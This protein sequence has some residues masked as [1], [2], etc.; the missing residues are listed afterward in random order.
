[1]VAI[2][3][4][5]DWIGTSGD[6]VS[7]H[8]SP[9]SRAKVAKA[10][11]SDVPV[12]YQQAQH[13]RGYLSHL[14]GGTD[15]ARLNIPAWDMQGQCDVR[16]MSHVINAYLRRHDTYHSWFEMTDDDQIVRHTVANPRDINFV[17]TKHGEMTAPQW[18]EHVLSTPD[19]LQWDCF[20]FGIIQR[21]D[22]F[23][24]YISIDHVHTDAMFMGIVLVEI[25]MMYAALAAGSAPIPL[26]AAGSYDDYCVRQRDYLAALTA[27]TPAVRE[28]VEFAQRNDGTLPH[29]PFPLGDPPWSVSGDLLT[30]R[31]LDKQQSDRF[32]AACTAAGARFIGG[33][34]ACAAM[35]QQ[36]LTGSTEYHVITP[37]TTRQTPEEFQTTGWFTG[38]V[39][40][41]VDVDPASFGD[42]ARAAQKSFD[43]RMY[44]ADVPFDRVLELADPELG[45]HS[46]PP[47]VPMVSFLD[48]GLPP[49]SASIIA[50]WERMNGRVFGDARSAYQ[51]GL[52]VNRGERETTVTVAY[53]NNP[54]ARESIDRYLEAMTAIYVGVADGAAHGRTR[55]HV[56]HGDSKHHNGVRD[57]EPVPAAKS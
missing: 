33:V 32:E 19:P 27:E 54:I 2:K 14:A 22:H 18:R 40:I 28:W 17:P 41:S 57:R 12:S 29:F 39:P 56:G 31:L 25:H 11:V 43:G 23:T 55:G 42:T 1:M 47:G 15:M 49:L 51:I 5:H 4:I 26:P 13:I 35:A 9:V 37:T 6:V 36:V 38:V 16:A 50:E 21:A 48:A 3:A 46:P 53:P 10:P 34:F 24:F 52:W 30:V 45:L 20:S 8:P 44:M 7:W